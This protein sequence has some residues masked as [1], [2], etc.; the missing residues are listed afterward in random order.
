MRKMKLE[1]KLPFLRKEGHLDEQKVYKYLNFYFPEHRGC[2]IQIG[3]SRASEP[4]RGGGTS[5]KFNEKGSI[6]SQNKD[7]FSNE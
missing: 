3:R 4:E 1:K 2:S 6:S 5:V 7:F